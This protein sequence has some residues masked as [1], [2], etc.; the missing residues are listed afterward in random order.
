MICE[1]VRFSELRLNGKPL[2]CCEMAM[3]ST[4]GEYRLYVDIDQ[5]N[6]TFYAVAVSFNSCTSEGD[7]WGCT[8]L[9]VDVLFTLTAL[10]D[11]VRH[12][13]TP[14]YLYYPDMYGLIE[15]LNKVADV[16]MKICKDKP[17]Q[18]KEQ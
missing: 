4:S 5:Q 15:L 3:E 10:H 2:N 1:N 12:L 11:G 13:D 9:T 18:I 6:K 17:S 8:N 16:E 7:V 14:G